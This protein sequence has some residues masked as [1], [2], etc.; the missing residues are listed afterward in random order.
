M[1]QTI[2][3]FLLLFSAGG[4]FAQQTVTGVVT[5]G[6]DNSPLPGASIV[7]MGT[8]A[9]SVTDENG[10]YTIELPDLT[11]TLTFSFIGFQTVE[12]AVNG[13]TAINITLSPSTEVLDE[14]VITALGITRE[15]KALG[16]AVTE[17]SGAE[18]NQ[19]KESNV[20]NQLSGRV[21]GVVITQSAAGPG[22]GSRVVIRGNNSLTGNNQPLYVVDG[23]PMD[24][25]GFGSAAGSGTANYR[26]DDYGTGISDINADDIE[27]ISV[28][29]GPNA[30]A[31]YGSR[32]SNGVIIINTKS[33]KLTSGIGVTY[34]GNF[35]FESPML[36]P[37]LQNEYGGGTDGNIPATWDE[38]MTRAGDSWGPRMDGSNQFYF[39]ERDET[40][41]Y[42][43]QPDNVKDFFET[44]YNIVNTVA[45]DF[46]SEKVSSRL[47]YTNTQTSSILPNAGL[48]RNN[49][50]LRATARLSD[51]L[52]FDA[53]VTYFKQEADQR[54]ARGDHGLSV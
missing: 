44:G 45:F 2:I 18:M 54:P 3:I 8:T 47:S 30:A 40:R 28:L 50:N 35:T 34:S 51:K 9:G 14:V 1:R 5:S 42:S 48:V 6:E 21:A 4:L 27:S 17:V 31:L 7:L 38:Y 16:F 26:R 25:S 10:N 19:V 22:S 32:A 37:K 49:L 12:E 39:T 24:N 23:I 33:G 53:K 52:S 43:A 15:K 29:K 41:P 13:R 20:I 46:G 36:L 11:G